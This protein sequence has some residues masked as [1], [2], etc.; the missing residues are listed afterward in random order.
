[1]SKTK[2]S[3]IPQPKFKL[4]QEVWLIEDNEPEEKKDEGQE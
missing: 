2:K 3:K 4:G 1:M